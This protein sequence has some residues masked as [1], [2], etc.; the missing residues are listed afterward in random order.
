M[1][2]DGLT[3]VERSSIDHS[4]RLYGFGLQDIFKWD[5]GSV[6]QFKKYSFHDSAHLSF[7]EYINSES[8][9]K[10]TLSDATILEF[11]W[12]YYID[13]YAHYQSMHSTQENS[14]QTVVCLNNL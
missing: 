5:K 11:D 13:L 1:Q 2:V 12:H 8:E 9:L 6:E 4:L 3:D 10:F 14:S 7:D